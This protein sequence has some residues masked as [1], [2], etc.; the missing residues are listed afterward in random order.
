MNE[1]AAD[2]A[3]LVEGD[4]RFD[5][6]SRTLYSTDASIYDI[7]PIGVVVPETE[8]D[9][10]EVTKYCFEKEIPILPRGGGSSLS[11]QA[12]GKAV[13]L[14]F[15]E[16]LDAVLEVNADEKWVRVQP[17]VILDEL[18]RQLEPH[19]LTFGPDPASSSRAAVGGMVG[20]NST[21]AHSIIH[22]ATSDHVLSLKVLLS[23]GDIATFE[24]VTTDSE[25]F[26]KSK[27]GSSF[28]SEIVR[29]T[30]EMAEELAFEC[31]HR[32]PKIRRSVAGYNLK[33]T[34]HE[35]TFD[36][37]KLVCGSEGTLV[38]VLEA[39][40]SLIDLPKA[41]GM[42]VLCFHD[43]IDALRAVAPIL[44]HGPSAL[45]VVD[46]MLLSMSKSNLEHGETAR[47]LPD[48][49][50]ALL[51]VEF[52]GETETEIQPKL[53]A[54]RRLAADEMKLAFHAMEAVDPQQQNALW[55]LRKAGLPILMSRPG[56]S[57]PTAFVE[58]TAVPPE[59]L[60]EYISEFLD[61]VKRHGTSAAVYAHAGG[62]C[63]H[64]RP[65]I[66][67]KSTA[68]VNRIYEIADAVTDLVIRYGGTTAS[69]HGDGLARTQ[70]L[71][72]LYGT[73][74]TDAFSKLKALFDP[75]GIMNPGKIVEPYPD[76]RENIR[77][78]VDQEVPKIRTALHFENQVD[79]VR[80]VEMCNGCGSCRNP[81][82]GVMCPS[83][84][85]APTEIT[86]T[87]GRANMMRQA[88]T[89]KLP[90][91][92]LTSR[93]FK[94]EVL[95]LCLGCKACK[96]ECPSGVDLAKL[97]SEIKYQY[98]QEHGAS[99][100]DRIFG[101][102]DRF[103][104]IGSAFAPITNL[105]NRNDLC[106]VILEKFAGID[107]RR[108]IPSFHWKTFVR[109][110]NERK[111][112]TPTN[113]R[114]KVAFF[115]DCY[116]NHN[117]PLLGQ[118]AVEVL[119]TLGFE[120]TLADRVCCGRAMLSTGL[121]DD[122]RE[123]AHYNVRHLGDQ[124]G[125]GMAVVGCEPSCMVTIQDDYNDILDSSSDLKLVQG[126]TFEIMEFLNI[127]HSDEPF[128]FINARIDDPVLIHGHCHQKAAGR[129]HHAVEL[130]N[131]LPGNESTMLDSGC[132]GMAGS[133][134]YEKDHYDLSMNIGELLFQQIRGHEG[135]IA[136]SGVSCRSQMFDGL[137]INARHPVE[138][139]HDAL[140]GA[141]SDV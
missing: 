139:L 81:R 92:E 33:E 140:L 103:S 120:V 131:L 45:E 79:L 58:D 42:I 123:K 29:G 14:D 111:I 64:I 122:A 121:I 65:V 35:N 137:G 62:G 83:F 134:G 56:D 5:D 44:E 112:Q 59:N 61:L 80:A 1:I 41:T 114:G 7:T 2:L 46:D 66:N 128:D 49:T 102:I 73:R 84:R 106:R 20:N 50:G 34:L 130:L 89:G 75:K 85:G 11:G 30:V 16:N 39:K 13:I 107:R 138:I 69:E 91:S 99:W 3:E 78:R 22:G 104:E 15:T 60:P 53:E 125:Q 17:G 124:V 136:A 31:Q 25:K 36:L 28:E 72:R 38:T 74:L 129:A 108:S 88:L 141:K 93:R 101:H 105:L 18:N 118:V 48:E 19:G 116:L 76:L 51:L 119:E 63:L 32:Y 117:N 135:V 43:L 26:L 47:S 98:I 54:V 6:Y 21:G 55:N 37:C 113:P 90:H 57:K 109:W 24:P 127:S 68:E 40:L 86:S 10:V 70:W 77:Y 9:V 95:D 87:R 97:K 115:Y 8:Q 94:E 27:N 71:K 82:G 100:G 4:V 67:L 132:C 126:R 12:I 110:F 133:F 23:N 96:R 52:Y